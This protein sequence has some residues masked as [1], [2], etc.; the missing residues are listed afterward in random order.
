MS[1]LRAATED[2]PQRKLYEDEKDEFD[3]DY[4]FIKEEEQ[5]KMEM[6]Q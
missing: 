4:S 5:M 2:E 6:L 3:N 1:F